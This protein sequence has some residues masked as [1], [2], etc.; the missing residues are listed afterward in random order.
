[1]RYNPGKAALVFRK[2]IFHRTEPVM[3]EHFEQGDTCWSHRRRSVGDGFTRLE[4]L[5]VVGI[6]ALLIALLLPNVRVARE[7]A[8]RNSCNNLFKQ[9][10]LALQNY[11]ELWSVFPPAHTIDSNGKKLHNWRTLILPYI[12][13]VP[14]YK[15][16]D[17][18][19]PWDDPANA[20]A[21]S[22]EVST[23][24]CPSFTG[25]PTHTTYFA[26]VTPESCMRP[27]QSVKLVDI[28]DGASRT[29]IVI[30]APSDRAVP[31]MSPQDASED[32]LLAI[33][34]ESK[35]AHPS[36]FNVGYA[37]GSVRFLASDSPAEL[38]RALI[39]VAGKEPLNPPD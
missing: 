10:G 24:Q 29:L 31:W 11:H 23:Y 32:D 28:A 37:D 7:A 38:R 27:G 20:K 17:L 14:L 1:M 18:A 39:T 4:M 3:V 6:I 13:E 8:R 9:I 33:Q 15:S 21:L 12:E 26:V 30:E 2:L 19:K 36:G 5:A 25:A 22:T 35:L 16:I 34:P